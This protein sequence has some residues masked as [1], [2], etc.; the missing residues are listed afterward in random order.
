MQVAL[1]VPI[2]RNLVKPL[3][4][5]GSLSRFQISDGLQLP[6]CEIFGKIRH[7]R[8]IFGNEVLGSGERDA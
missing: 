6:R 8:D 3:A 7:R 2:R 4:N 1:V 5:D